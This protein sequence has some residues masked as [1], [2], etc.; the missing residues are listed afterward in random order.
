MKR[1]AGFTLIEIMLVM[2]LLALSSVAVIMTMPK[3]Q[4]NEAKDEAVRFY[5]LSQLLSEDAMQSGRDYGINVSNHG[6]RFVVLTQDG[7][8]EIKEK[9]KYYNQVET[10][11]AITLVYEKGGNGR[12]RI[13]CLNKI[14]CFLKRIYLKKTLMRRNVSHRK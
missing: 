4:N 6:Y 5:Q 9:T 8:Q 3:N 10:P 11:K 13:G 12:K 1:A 7:W 2:V 14:N